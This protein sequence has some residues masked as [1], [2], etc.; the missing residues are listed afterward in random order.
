MTCAFCKY[1]WCWICGLKY[2]YGH[3]DSYFFGCPLIQ[4]TS[5]DWS[6]CRIFMYQV[7]MVIFWPLLCFI[8]CIVF[9]TKTICGCDICDNL[10]CVT[11]IF[12]G[13]LYI[14]VLCIMTPILYA[15][16]IIPTFVYRIYILLYLFV[17]IMRNC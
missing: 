9:A 7:I 11:G 10:N 6:L 16:L 13:G 5:S 14:V 15:A 12:C 3:F 17:R 8:S 1:E 4:F 2:D